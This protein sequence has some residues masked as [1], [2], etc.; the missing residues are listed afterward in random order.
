MVVLLVALALVVWALV[1][2]SRPVSNDNSPVRVVIPKGASANEIASI[3][4]ANSLI[5]NPLMFSMTCRFSG[6]SERLKPGV[7]EFRRTMSLPQIVRRLVL[8]ETV[9][10]W[11]TIPE[12]F[13]VRQIA[14]LLEQKNLVNA[15][16]FLGLAMNQGYE[17]PTYSFVDDQSLE[18]YLFPDTYLLSK[19]VGAKSVINKML[20]A[21]QNKV[22]SARRSEIESEIVT[23]FGAHT[24]FEDGLHRILTLASLVEREAKVP[25][26]RALIAAVLWNR[27]AKNMRLEVDAT[28]TYEP[29]VSRGNK[30]DVYY[31]DLES[32]SPYNTYKH[33]GLPPGPI[34]N[35]GV[36]SIDAVLK[37]ASVDYVY[38]VAKPD[39]SHVFSRTYEEHLKAK[40]AIKNGKP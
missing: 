28:V 22:L 29:G 5:R 36:A 38:Y 23:R 17:F 12:G 27:L 33:F 8:A 19:G 31:R 1:L 30:S 32:D 14:D 9:E 20:Q 40:N 26:D 7:Y 39:G 4:Q 37:P 13:T 34:C 15:Q 2:G 21:F 3:L 35:P 24:T 16:A 10:S 18:G 6:S 11:V 25:K